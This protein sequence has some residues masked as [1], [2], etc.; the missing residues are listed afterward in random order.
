MERVK[1]QNKGVQ[2]I[3]LILP[4]DG[5]VQ[6]DGEGVVEVSERCA[7][8]LLSNGWQI[9]GTKKETKVVKEETPT[10]EVEDNETEEV[11]D[12]ASRFNNM[13]VGELRDLAMEIGFNE[14]EVK[15]KKGELV[16]MLVSKYAEV[17][18]AE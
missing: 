12:I 2:N 1:I 16:E 15:V 11:D 6:I 7:N 5:L 13:K 4:F 18:N 3:K 10:E 14:E 17:D 9:L 8:V